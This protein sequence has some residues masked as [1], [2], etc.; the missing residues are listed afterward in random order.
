[1]SESLKIK[2]FYL[3]GLLFILLNTVAIVYQFFL[4][5]WLAAN[6]TYLFANHLPFGF[7]FTAAGFSYSP[8]N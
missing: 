5:G 8:I 7:T 6:F 3:S 2:L 4:V 1:M